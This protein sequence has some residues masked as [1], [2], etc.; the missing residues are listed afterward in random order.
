[1][2][3]IAAS[4]GIVMVVAT[5]HLYRWSISSEDFSSVE[6]RRR[7]LWSALSDNG[8]PIEVKAGAEVHITH[9]LIEELRKNRKNLVINYSNYMFLEFPSTHIIPGV[10]NLI[11]DLM[12]EG[13]TP[14]IAHPERNY[15]FAKNP[16]LLY[17]LVQMGV[18]AQANGG[19]LTG[20][21]GR[22]AAETAVRFLTW[23]LIHF[24]A[25]DGHHPES[26]PPRLAAAVKRAETV[27]GKDEA[28]HLVV[29]NPKAVLEDR[30]VP[31]L[32]SPQDP[33]KAKRSFYIRIPSF[34]KKIR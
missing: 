31:Y 25:S 12:S 1:M 21:Y 30:Q 9:N 28:R 18:L 5:P 20:L 4:E 15:G 34:P 26:I 27:L 17:E 13:I 2:A 33:G 16:S 3:R 10:K 22:G 19:S 24:L 6:E 29:G 7:D 8:S 14:I 32:P 23:S 11:F